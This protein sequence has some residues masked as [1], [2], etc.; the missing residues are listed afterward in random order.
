MTGI[1]QQSVASAVVASAAAIT[2]PS[3]V[4]HVS[5]TAE[6][7]TINPPPLFN[8]PWIEII[9]DG[10]FTTGTTGNIAL[11]STAVVNKTLRLTYD[12]TKWYPSY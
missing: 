10:I 8:G 6:I 1:S 9:P 5:G 3:P 11:A 2:A 12:G 4:F 7:D